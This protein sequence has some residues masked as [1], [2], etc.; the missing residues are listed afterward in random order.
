MGPA[1][2]C[3]RGHQRLAG[4]GRGRG[5]RRRRAA[6]RTRCGPDRSDRD[7]A[8]RRRSVDVVVV[9]AGVAGL[10]AARA[11][12][13]AGRD[14]AVLEAQDRVGGRL[15][16]HPV[17]DRGL[18]LGA[19]WFWSNEPRIQALIAELGLGTH[20]QH[21]EGD[22]LYQD[23]RGVQ[24]LQGNPIDGPAGRVTAGMQ[25][26]ATAMGDTLPAGVVRLG[27]AVE[28]IEVTKDGIR[29]YAAR[30]EAAGGE[31]VRVAVDAGA[32]VLA[33]PPALATHAITFEPA[34]P[35]ALARLAAVT[36]VWMGAMTKAVIHYARPF[37]RAT[38]LAGAAI[39]H[40]GPLRE[41]HD[42]SGPD[43]EPAALFGFVPPRR[44]GAPTPTADAILRQLETLFGPEA[45][46]PTDVHVVDWR[47]DEYTAPPGADGLQNY[48]TYGHPLYRTPTLAG[49]LHWAST[50][51]STEVPGHIEGALAAGARAA[52]AVLAG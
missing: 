27:H 4:D 40:V 23:T 49:R 2:G 25:A 47:D 32:V 3:D 39:S 41:I 24:R 19:T 42:M 30:L 45:A 13:A 36:P 26:V 17:G 1:S 38:G 31:S 29:V 16:S 11:L 34:L 8:A 21:L 28:R 14:V 20:A 7:A 9:G 44:P 52:A 15:L 51:T 18:D 5:A 46:D 37:W 35:E 6:V 50:E 22:A 48:A 43:G 10:A 12:G 33:L